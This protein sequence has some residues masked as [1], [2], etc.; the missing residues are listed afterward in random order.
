MNHVLEVEINAEGDKLA[1]LSPEGATGGYRIAGPKAW[2]GSRNLARLN[3][4]DS[5]LE[6][7]VR[8]YAEE[9]AT[10]ISDK[11]VQDFLT[12]YADN[13]DSEIDVSL[14]LNRYQ[15]ERNQ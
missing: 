4:S 8:G 11:A 2:G 10:S 12:W 6:R 3:V 5:D 1:Y 9:V 14:I 7:Y 13:I 15:Q